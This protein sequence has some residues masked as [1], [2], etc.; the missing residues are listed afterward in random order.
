MAKMPNVATS[1]Q[2]LSLDNCAKIPDFLEKSGSEPL[3][4]IETMKKTFL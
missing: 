2:V 4:E 1:G 3:A